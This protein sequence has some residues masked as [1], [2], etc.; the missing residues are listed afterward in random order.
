M[1]KGSIVKPSTH[2]E[3]KK[4]QENEETI[5]NLNK[6]I[7]FLQKEVYEKNA[8]VEENNILN[9]DIKSLKSQFEAF[10]LQTEVQKKK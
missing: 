1:N 8:K 7:A 9:N 10:K 2:G 6:M 5:K 4:S 3:H